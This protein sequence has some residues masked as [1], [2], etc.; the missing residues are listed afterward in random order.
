M[1]VLF[2]FLCKGSISVMMGDGVA[3][4]TKLY[5]LRTANIL[6]RPQSTE[7]GLPVITL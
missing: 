2:K 1:I 5:R 7:E 3:V 6:K 4:S